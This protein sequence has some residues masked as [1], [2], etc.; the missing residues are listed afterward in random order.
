[1]NLDEPGSKLNVAAGQ[2]Y[3]VYRETANNLGAQAV[4]A[5]VFR[6]K[7]TGFNLYKELKR[8]LVEKG[9]PADEI[10]IITDASTDARRT[11]MIDDVRKGKVRV[12]MGSTEKLGVGINMQ[13]RLAALHHL[14][15]PPRPMDREQ[16]MGRMIRQGNIFD[17]VQ[18]FVYG[19]EGSL[20]ATLSKRLAIKQRFINQV[21]KGD[22]QG[23]SFED[24]ADEVTLSYDEQMAAF[25]GNPLA[26][27]RVA[28]EMRV[29]QLEGLKRGHRRDQSQ[30]R[31]RIM[32]SERSIPIARR[33]GK[34][35]EEAADEM[36]A[37]LKVEEYAVGKK[38]FTDWKKANKA[39]DEAITR[40]INAAESVAVDG[41]DRIFRGL[42]VW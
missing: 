36:E 1:V 12:I 22:I 24:A 11:A 28:T 6:N 39:I 29:Q 32:N 10:A 15:V 23:R 26:L 3:R 17:E 8:K 7:E 14:D 42:R 21:L 9:V 25:S 40:A 30:A 37:A 35:L 19:V 13:D 38:T 34:R 2:I 33:A 20:D 27:E 16:R 31:S 5:D 18:D 41:G 4:F